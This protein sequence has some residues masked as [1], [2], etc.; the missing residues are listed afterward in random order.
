MKIDEY[1]DVNRRRT[2]KWKLDK[3]IP[4]ALIVSMITGILIAA[5]YVSHQETRMSLIEQTITVLITDQKRQD[6]DRY[7]VRAEM[8]DMFND[9]GQSLRGLSGKVDRVL[10]SKGR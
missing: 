7:R 4:G 5:I 10:E 8:R 1:N 9:I 6:D 2:D 3:S